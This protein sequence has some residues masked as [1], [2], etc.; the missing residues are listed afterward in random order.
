VQGFHLAFLATFVLGVLAQW[1]W[2]TRAR[3]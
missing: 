1:V 2:L 3:D